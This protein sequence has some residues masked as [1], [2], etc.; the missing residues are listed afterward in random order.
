MGM[1]NGQ[2]LDQR[3]DGSFHVTTE[4]AAIICGVTVQSY[5]G[6]LAQPMPPP[7]DKENRTVPLK[8][9]GD[10]I[11]AEQVL[12]RGRGGAGF[13][14]A[15]NIDKLYKGRGM[16]GVPENEHPETRLKRLQAD[17]LQIEMDRTAGALISV[18]EA[19]QTWSSIITRVKT[20]F[21]GMPVKMAPLLSG[22]TDQHEI[23]QI[24]SDGVHEA[25]ESLADGE[26]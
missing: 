12:K 25:L 26:E 20:K 24:L 8:E 5:R 1:K 7:Y 6:W 13:P 3:P 10:W 11:R 19:R 2:H 17:K 22:L 4:L 23:Q 9:L 16:P 18:D 21:L 14:Y 15:P